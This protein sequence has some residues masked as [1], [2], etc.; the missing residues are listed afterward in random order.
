MR[1]LSPQIS[2]KV[3]VIVVDSVVSDQ[4]QHL[5]LCFLGLL[6]RD[7][8]YT[9]QHSRSHYCHLKLLLQICC[10]SLFKYLAQLC[11]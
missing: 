1:L 4:S 11:K 9:I 5:H 6:D 10:Y 8:L 7:T 2:L 3:T